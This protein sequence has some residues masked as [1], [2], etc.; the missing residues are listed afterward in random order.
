MC[1]RDEDLSSTA[2]LAKGRRPTEC[3]PLDFRLV[4]QFDIHTHTGD[5]TPFADRPRPRSIDLSRVTELERVEF[6]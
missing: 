5:F 3:P 1:H 6:P 2:A 4:R